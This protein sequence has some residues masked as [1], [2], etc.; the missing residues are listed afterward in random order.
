MSVNLI[1][2]GILNSKCM[3]KTG[4]TDQ[5]SKLSTVQN[6][7]DFVLENFEKKNM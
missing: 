7:I 2:Q 4:V 3:Q 1:Y 5:I 6:Y